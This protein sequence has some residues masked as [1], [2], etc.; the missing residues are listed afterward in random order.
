MPERTAQ[1]QAGLFKRR[2]P[3]GLQLYGDGSSVL[4]QPATARRV[5]L[6]LGAAVIVT[7][8]TGVLATL[9]RRRAL[10]ARQQSG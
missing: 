7:V 9:A 10:R 8:L 3:A 4:A 1:R 2:K 5:A 6:F